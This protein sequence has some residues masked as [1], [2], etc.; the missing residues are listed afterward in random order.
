MLF[1]VNENAYNPQITQMDADKEKTNRK[2]A[3]HLNSHLRCAEFFFPSSTGRVLSD[4]VNI[5]FGIWS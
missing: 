4:N 3:E 2:V 1:S 5:T